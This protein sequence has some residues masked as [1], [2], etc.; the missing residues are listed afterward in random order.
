MK[1]CLILPFIYHSQPQQFNPLANAYNPNNM[2]N[3]NNPQQNSPFP[4]QNVTQYAGS[5]F[6]YFPQKPYNGGFP[7]NNF[8]DFSRPNYPMTLV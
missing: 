3:P 4:G 6:P 7:V 1:L 2:F 8:M 5:P